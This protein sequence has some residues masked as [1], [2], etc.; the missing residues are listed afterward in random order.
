MYSILSCIVCRFFS[1]FFS[2]LRTV[3][4]LGQGAGRTGPLCPTACLRSTAV[5][6]VFYFL[7][8]LIC[9]LLRWL[10]PGHA[11]FFSRVQGAGG[12]RV[13]RSSHGRRFGFN[14]N[15]SLSVLIRTQI[16]GQV[17]AAWCLYVQP[18]GRL[19]HRTI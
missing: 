2:L 7:P 12:G 1:F 13:K 18:R 16:T 15:R 5:Y 9:V 4:D 6:I 11:F 8:D 19:N 17:L 14:L 10:L 3:G